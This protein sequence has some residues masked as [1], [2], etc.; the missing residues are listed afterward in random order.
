MYALADKY[1]IVDLKALAKAKFEEAVLQDWQSR[2]FVHA[3]ELVF[4][5]THDSDQ[6]LRGAVVSTINEHR[7]LINYEEW[8]NLF[9]SGNGMAWALVQ[10]LLRTSE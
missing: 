3:A 10:I 6:G 2:A 1:E 5:T 4:S 9:N 8:Q 7:E